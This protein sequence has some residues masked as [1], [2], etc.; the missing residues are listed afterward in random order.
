M[1]DAGALV[2]L[3]RDDRAAWAL[4]LLAVRERAA[5]RVPTGAIGQAWRDGARQVLLVRA[6]RHCDEVPLDGPQARAA[7]ALCA[8]ACTN[9][10][11]DATV[12]LVAAAPR[13]ADVHIV[14]SDPDDLGVLLD[15]LDARNV[16]LV[17]A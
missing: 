4:L 3:D 10:V 17:R 12:A 6:L 11:I 1:L 5:V 14:T 13:Q 16:G 8:R 15:V 7:G 2:A 9:D